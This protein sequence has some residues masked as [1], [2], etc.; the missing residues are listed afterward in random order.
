MKEGEGLKDNTQHG[1]C[2]LKKFII[3]YLEG[4]WYGLWSSPWSSPDI[5]QQRCPRPREGKG[6]AEAALLPVYCV[7]VPPSH[8]N[9]FSII[10]QV[11]L[12]CGKWDFSGC[13]SFNEFSLWALPISFVYLFWL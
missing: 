4:P 2:S 6:L 10:V 5:V 1:F 11:L 8:A 13:S 3:S 12:L 7:N 9:A